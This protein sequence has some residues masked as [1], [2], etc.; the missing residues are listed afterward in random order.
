M[1]LLPPNATPLERALEA[2]TARIAD[3]EAPIANL[4]NPAA[5]PAAILPWLAWGLSV[6]SWDTEWTEAMK[7]DTIAQSIDFHRRKGT[8]ASIETVLARFDALL[9]IAEWFEVT[10][11]RDPH[12][13]DVVLPVVVTDPATGQPHAPGGERTSGAFAEAIVREI[14][15]VKPLR[16]HFRLAQKMPAASAIRVVAAA[17]TAHWRRDDLA[18]IHDTSRDW[19]SD[20]QTED[21]EPLQREDGDPLMETA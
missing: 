17:R 11:R 10:P 3:V 2:A 16:E 12:T 15:R 7:R 20:L 8:R 1:T 19:A 13:F 14:A 5:C 21:G 9:T 6:D 4:W 18:L